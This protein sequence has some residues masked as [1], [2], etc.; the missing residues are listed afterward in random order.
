MSKLV[1]RT[2]T[3]S[4]DKKGDPIRT[5]F[6]K[7]NLNFTS[8]FDFLAG[9]P[10]AN[11][12]PEALPI[13][14]G[15]TGATTMQGARNALGLTDTA[16][17]PVGIEEGEVMVIGAYGFGTDYSPRAVEADPRMAD[18]YKSGE[19]EC[20]TTDKRSY[21]TLATRDS[22][23]KYQMGVGYKDGVCTPIYRYSNGSVFSE[24]QT[25]LG[26]QNTAI[27]VNGNVKYCANS[28]RL[29]SG[30]GT[31]QYGT[32]VPVTRNGVGNY[33]VPVTADT[34]N[35]T[36]EVPMDYKGTTQFD[37]V[38]S[39]VGSD[40]NVVVTKGGVAYDIPQGQWIDIH[41]K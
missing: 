25:I 30:F 38:L 34:S 27:T 6:T 15:G 5:A 23:Q 13:N 16:S 24:W 36:I 33:T 1:I 35:W 12:L 39:Q 9:A 29:Y 14:A 8:L 31:N 37:V 18:S 2:G 10:E 21:I 11:G 22:T 7:M 41:I 40:L 28:M 17:L 3:T 19:L 26:T 20:T 32:D 4:N